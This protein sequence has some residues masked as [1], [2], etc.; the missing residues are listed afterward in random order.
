MGTMTIALAEGTEIIECHDV[1]IDNSNIS[2]KTYD[3]LAGK[4]NTLFSF[5][6]RRQLNC[7]YCAKDT[8]KLSFMIKYDEK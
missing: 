7:M 4:L 8:K 5:Q 6:L 2:A 3:T 1:I